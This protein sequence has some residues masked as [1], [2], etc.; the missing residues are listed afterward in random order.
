[1]LMLFIPLVLVDLSPDRISVQENRGLANLPNLTDLKSHPGFFISQFDTWFKDSTGFREQML[2]LYNVIDKTKSLGVQ[3]RYVDGQLSYLIGENGH[4]YFAG[5]Y[6]V[7]LIS[8]YQGKQ[9]LSDEQ[10]QTMAVKLEEV[11]S[12][13]DHKNIPLVV[14]FCTDKES[15]YPEYYPKS[16]KPGP[17]PIQLEI[18]TSYLQEHTSVNIFNI[19]QALLEEKDN[20][21]LY[22]I[23]GN[24][25]ALSHYNGIGAFFAYRELILHIVSYFPYITP[26]GLSDVDISYD[27]KGVHNV[28]LK[29]KTYKKLEPSFFDNTSFIDDPFLGLGFNAA[30]E[31]LV[32][33]LPVILLLRTSYSNEEYAGKFIAQTFG[34]TIMTH[35]S[36]LEHIEEYIA[37]F[38][39]D[40][41]VFEST[42]YQLERFAN[43]VARIPELP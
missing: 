2:N 30:Y 25:A 17:E 6:E 11:K 39:P 15:I 20:Y 9:F 14:M 31:N 3:I 1:M 41:V 42:E 27:E 23:S 33:D 29:E 43:S 8:K 28:S 4:H 24:L 16:V 22:A 7:S 12:Y 19:R 40:I 38:K 10:L 5:T 35:F 32:P 18:I 13:L 37:L 36:N 34:R 21:L 26:L